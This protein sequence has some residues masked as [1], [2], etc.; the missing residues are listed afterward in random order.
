MPALGKI[1]LRKEITRTQVQGN[2][3]RYF[4]FGDNEA[5]TGFG[6]QA[7]AMRGEPNAIG[8]RTKRYPGRNPE[9]YWTDENYARNCKMIDEDLAKVYEVI[10]EGDWVVFPADGIGTGRAELETRAPRTYEYLQRRLKTII[11]SYKAE[12]SL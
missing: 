9:D 3:Y 4:V 10:S 11:E 2:P 8:I 1:V 12:E 7:R 6:G 5:R